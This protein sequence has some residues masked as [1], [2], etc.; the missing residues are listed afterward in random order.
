MAK[1]FIIFKN[2]YLLNFINV[3][4]T[5]IKFYIIFLLYVFLIQ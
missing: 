5:I 1:F 4:S 2:N 3:I